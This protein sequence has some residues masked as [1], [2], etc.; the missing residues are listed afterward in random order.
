MLNSLKFLKNQG[1]RAIFVYADF[2][3]PFN[4]E[5]SIRWYNKKINYWKQ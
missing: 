1:F 3:N 5:N 2:M 4:A